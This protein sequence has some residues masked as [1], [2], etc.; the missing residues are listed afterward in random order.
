MSIRKID[1]SP[2]KAFFI[3]NLTRDL[4]LED[5]ILDLVDNSIDA[6]IQNYGID[7]SPEL[8]KG[9]QSLKRKVPDPLVKIRIK[10]NSIEVRDWAGGI[11]PALAPDHV[12]RLG[13][14]PATG[15]STLGVYGIGLK[16]A[17]F[18]MGD[19]VLIESRHK[20]GGF[21]VRL[22]VPTW[23]R[24]DTNWALPVEAL[25]A[26]RSQ[27]KAGT[28]ILVKELRPEIGMRVG[29]PATL[30]RL[31]DYIASTYSLFLGKFLSVELNGHRVE[32]DPI[33]LGQSE[34]VLAARTELTQGDV[35]VE[36][37]AG[38]AERRDDDWQMDTAG[39]YILC[40]G[41]VVVAANKDQLTG[42]GVLG[43]QFVSKYRG[44]VG[45]AFFFSENP[46]SLPWTTTKR[47]LNRESEVFQITRREMASAAKPVIRFLNN[48][49]PSD[50]GEGVAERELAN[51]IKPTSIKTIASAPSRPFT[52]GAASKSSQP[53]TVRVQFD[54][55]R[56]DIRRI[57]GCLSKPRWGASQVGRHAL[58]RLMETECPE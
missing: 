58:K 14:P 38:L 41:R 3:E 4:S 1:A 32:P 56:E 11:D 40:N 37:F 43:P 44:F 52:A 45:V 22:N 10:E 42:W 51:A 7:A 39:W 50:P 47:G 49:Y 35:H 54:A 23:L 34:E 55:K 25:P 33:P 29:D 18:K 12:F 15:S 27:S 17:V 31:R 26:A 36:L 9:V 6:A 8:L 21:R 19:D 30:R 28:R 2:T 46:G 24:N 16:R 13:R 53:K 57:K 5:A 20:D 48:M